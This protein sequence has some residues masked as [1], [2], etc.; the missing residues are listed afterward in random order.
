M[1]LALRVIDLP[2]HLVY[3]VIV[4][5]ERIV[6]IQFD[7]Y[8][9]GIVQVACLDVHAGKG[10]GRLLIAGVDSEYVL[11]DRLGSV[12]IV[13]HAVD[14]T[15][16]DQD[17]HV[18]RFHLR[19]QFD[20]RPGLVVLPQTDKDHRLAHERIHVLG[21]R[22]DDPVEGSDCTGIVPFL[23]LDRGFGYPVL[24]IIQVH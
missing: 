18:E 19:S 16:D 8:G 23:L 11:A 9:T 4:I 2:Q 3:L 7:Q 22:G 1:G 24:R 14:V 12:R 5:G 6:G 15:L 20:E 10:H 21:V 17:L 13:P